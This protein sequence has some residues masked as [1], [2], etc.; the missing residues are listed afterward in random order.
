MLET[1]R[2]NEPVAV[3]NGFD[4][5]MWHPDHFG[6]C[7]I[8]TNFFR[9]DTP[10]LSE[11]RIVV[12]INTDVLNEHSLQLRILQTV[13][14]STCL[15]EPAE[16]TNAISEYCKKYYGR[17]SKCAYEFF[18]AID[19]GKSLRQ[20]LRKHKNISVSDERFRLLY[21]YFEFRERILRANDLRE[22]AHKV[23]SR[24]KG[25]ALKKMLDVAKIEEQL[26]AMIQE[27]YWRNDGL[28]NRKFFVCRRWERFEKD[29]K[30]CMCIK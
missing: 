14:Q 13:T 28:F 17:Y 16:M 18:G 19:N 1:I 5:G 29:R 30:F 4:Y 8:E 15:S 27:S 3:T 12:A 26:L 25:S 7:Y 11:A 6:D 10:K 22:S 21:T 2:I 9:F 23:V 24:S 20:L